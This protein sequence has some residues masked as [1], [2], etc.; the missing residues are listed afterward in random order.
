MFSAIV[1]RWPRAF[2]TIGFG[3]T[4]VAYFLLSTLPLA[5]SKLDAELEDMFDR[6]ASI[7]AMP[8]LTDALSADIE[9]IRKRAEE[10]SEANSLAYHFSQIQAWLSELDASTALV[11]GAFCLFFSYVLGEIVIG[12]GRSVVARPIADNDDILVIGRVAILEN[13]ILDRE[14]E[15]YQ[16][17]L[18]VAYGL[19]GLT[20]IMVLFS[21][22]DFLRNGEYLKS[23]YTLAI[24]IFFMFFAVGF[25]RQNRRY[26]ETCMK[27]VEQQRTKTMESPL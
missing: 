18:L 2:T 12:I 1:P 22:S 26:L 3:F 6:I 8:S 9:D 14:Y 21:G 15:N 10:M 24:G 23:I 17:A 19:A 27:P 25:I 11:L 4:A 20:V 13:S 7:E 16:S 5:I